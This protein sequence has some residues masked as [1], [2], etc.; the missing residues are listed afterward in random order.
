MDWTGCSIWK[1]K[2]PNI[3]G[4]SVAEG[5]A[6]LP[7]FKRRVKVRIFG[8]HTADTTAE[9]LSDDDLP[10]AYCIF[11][12]TAGSGSGGM[13]QSTNFSG[14]EFVFG[15]FIDGEDAQQP[16]IL[17]VLDKWHKEN[18]GLRFPNGKFVP[19]SGYNNGV[20]PGQTDIKNSSDISTSAGGS[21]SSALAGGGQPGPA[22]R[23]TYK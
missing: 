16:C 3:P 14:G 2:H 4:Y 8:Y 9:G 15:F 5:E 19:F 20:A 23:T 6:S 22:S 13:S 1:L 21:T 12:V 7:G 18:F 10:W 11:P 17:G